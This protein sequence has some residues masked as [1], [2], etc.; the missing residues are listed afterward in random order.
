MTRLVVSAALAAAAL[1]AAAPPA[2]A[3]SGKSAAEIRKT[4]AK[5]RE[6]ADKASKEKELAALLAYAKGKVADKEA[7]LLAL[8]LIHI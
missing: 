6:T 4:F 8:S 3:Q 2:A 1:L 7:A 5:E